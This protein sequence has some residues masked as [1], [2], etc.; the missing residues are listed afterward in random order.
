VHQLLVAA[1]HRQEDEWRQLA[2]LAVWIMQPWVKKKITVDK[3]IKLP[4]RKTPRLEM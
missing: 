3:L 1:Q 2:Q 4:K